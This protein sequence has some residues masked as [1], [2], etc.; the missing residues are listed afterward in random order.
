MLNKTDQACPCGSGQLVKN[1]C[2]KY[3]NYSQYP[4][5]P[6][7]LMRS[8]YTAYVLK[9]EEYL[10]N[11]WHESTR[12]DS[13]ELENDTSQWKK[14]KVISASDNK[15]Q[16]V[17]YFVTIINAK[18][19]L[20]SLYEESLFIKE[21]HWFYLEGNDHKTTELTKNMPCPCRSGKKFKR[22]CAT[23]I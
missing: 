14:L 3:I 12:P 4:D 5:T 7:Q 19:H 6:E 1:C 13:L 22:C 8:R 21:D 11:S 17:A 2:G 9:N 16:F 10:L 20:F 15:V 18:E 23:E